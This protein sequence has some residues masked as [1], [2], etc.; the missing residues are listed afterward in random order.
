MSLFTVYDFA[1]I[2][3]YI[4][5]NI[6]NNVRHLI[7]TLVNRKYRDVWPKSKSLPFLYLFYTHY[8]VE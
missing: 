5:S 2:L 7:L 1:R 6:F 4:L 3:G 8:E